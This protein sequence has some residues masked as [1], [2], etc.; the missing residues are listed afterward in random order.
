MDGNSKGL[1]L[2]VSSSHNLNKGYEIVVNK[3]SFYSI[4]KHQISSLKLQTEMGWHNG[5]DTN[6]RLCNKFNLSTIEDEIH[7]PFNCTVLKDLRRIF[8]QIL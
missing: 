7:F 3:A 1:V 8:F 4:I 5:I 6:E 2:L